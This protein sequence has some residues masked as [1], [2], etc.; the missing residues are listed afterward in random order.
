MQRSQ[1]K[2]GIVLTTPYEGSMGVVVRV[3]DLVKSLA[4]MGVEVHVFSPFGVPGLGHTQRVFTHNLGNT[5]NQL[6]LSR[7][8]YRILQY[9][10]A[11]PVLARN[12]VLGRKVLSRIVRSLSETVYSAVKD[13]DVDVLQG[14]QELASIACLNIKDRL[15]VQVVS[16][17]HNI[18][19]EE[20]AASGVIEKGDSRFNY[21]MDWEQRISEDSEMVIVLSESMK[22]YL[23]DECGS[24]GAN[25]IVVP[26]GSRPKIPDIEYIPNPSR[27]VYAGLLSKLDNVDLFVESMPYIKK[28]HP[29]VSFHLTRKGETYSSIKEH[30]DRLGMTPDFF[31]YP[32]KDEFIDFLKRCHVGVITSKDHITRKF[33]FAIKFFDYLSVGIP[34]VVNDIGGWTK[35]VDYEKVGILTE[36]NPESFAKGVLELLHDPEMRYELG[37]RCLYLSRTR[38]NID[39]IA[40]SL[41][42]EYERL[43]A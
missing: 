26:L 3:T 5:A 7:T 22:D 41:S 29:N 43:V 31:W 20:L 1:L 13:V 17:L 28:E 42:K 24:R 27:V 18:W 34:V 32:T 16:S 38:F 40:E 33:G 6:G 37:R 11:K 25:I 35:I 30:A 9:C 10:L 4:S 39:R 8:V 14:E 36:S 19:P 12:V 15:D 23:Y 21:L 2:I